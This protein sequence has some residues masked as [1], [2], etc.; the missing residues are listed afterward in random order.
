MDN[1]NP[2]VALDKI[3]DDLY[4][5]DSN[6]VLIMEA[7][8]LLRRMVSDYN[9]ALSERNE[10]RYNAR[11]LAHAYTTDNRPPDR[12]VKESLA[13][14]VDQRLPREVALEKLKQLPAFD[15]TI[16]ATTISPE[17]KP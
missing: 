14:D 6:L 3:L 5:H 12:I 10:A 13:Y 11:I 17:K 15:E 2:A 4:E 8:K 9:T 1:T 16:L 7:K